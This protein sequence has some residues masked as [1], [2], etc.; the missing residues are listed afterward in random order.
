MSSKEG[1]K[2]RLLTFISYLRI[3]KSEF[4]RRCKLSNGYI[5]SIKGDIGVQKLMNMTRAFPQLNPYWVATG[6]GDMLIPVADSLMSEDETHPEQSTCH[7]LLSK[8]ANDDKYKAVMR[9]LT[10]I[11]KREEANQE[12]INKLQEA[13]K[14]KEDQINRLL[15]LVDKLNYNISVSSMES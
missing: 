15:N 13:L 10:Q 2:E 1:T 9:I 8:D 14:I 4:E 3:R 12:S 11:Q 7:S 5:N 6:N